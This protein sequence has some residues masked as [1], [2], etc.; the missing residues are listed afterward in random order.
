MSNLITSSI[1][2]LIQKKVLED[3]Q[4]FLTNKTEEISYNDVKSLI[5]LISNNAITHTKHDFNT[6]LYILNKQILNLNEEIYDEICL[7]Y[8]CK[9]TDLYKV[10]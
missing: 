2:E 6:I 8:L 4:D 3:N 1:L 9:L 10:I 7:S 5:N